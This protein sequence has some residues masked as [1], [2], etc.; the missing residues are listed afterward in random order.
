MV[1]NYSMYNL[2]ISG[3]ACIGNSLKLLAANWYVFNTDIIFY[4]NPKLI[5]LGLSLLSFLSILIYQ[6]F[7]IKAKIG[8]FIEKKRES[9]TVYKEYKLYVL[10]FGIAIILIEIINEIFKIRPKS[11]Y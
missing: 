7:K 2:L 4:N 1:E 8:Y 9:D 6:F 5:I 11:I 10:F 3:I